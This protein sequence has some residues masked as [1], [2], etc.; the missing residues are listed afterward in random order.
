MNHRKYLLEHIQELI[1][2]IISHWS[3]Q[4]EKMGISSPACTRTHWMGIYS[5]RTDLIHSLHIYP[6]VV[7]MMGVLSIFLFHTYNH[8][9]IYIWLGSSLAVILCKFIRAH[10]LLSTF[11]F[12]FFSWISFDMVSLK[13]QKLSF[14]D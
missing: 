13:M 14:K 4:I 2:L 3:C 5:Y 11:F 9:H 6:F 1:H 7:A 8:K 12:F 10:T